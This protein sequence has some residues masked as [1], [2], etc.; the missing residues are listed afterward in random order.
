MTSATPAPAAARQSDLP[1]RSLHRQLLRYAQSKTPNRSV[2]EDAVS[3]AVVAALQSGTCFDSPG[4]QRAWLIG[5]LKHK[6][7]DQLRQASRWVSLE[8]T[9]ADEVSEDEAVAPA[10]IEAGWAHDPAAHCAGRRLRHALER[11]CRELP[12]AQRAAFTLRELAGLEAD[13]ICDRLGITRNHLW[14]LIHRARQ[15]LRQQLGDYR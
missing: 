14:V 10:V 13:E 8:P 5:V 3:E 9:G 12:P 6:L 11:R 4:R 7:A 2:A 1:W 15:T